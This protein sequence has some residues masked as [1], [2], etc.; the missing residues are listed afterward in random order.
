MKQK[1]NTFIITCDN[2][3]V[4]RFQNGSEELNNIFVAQDT[5]NLSL[6]EVKGKTTMQR[7]KS[8]LGQTSGSNECCI[9]VIKLFFHYSMSRSNIT[10]EMCVNKE[11]LAVLWDM[12]EWL[13]PGKLLNSS[14]QWNRLCQ[15]C[16]ACIN[17]DSNTHACKPTLR[18]YILH[19][20]Y[21]KF[22]LDKEKQRKGGRDE[23]GHGK[24]YIPTP[25][26]SWQ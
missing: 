23:D 2:A 5:Q 10:L 19:L 9:N 8:Q 6:D 17:T 12:S 18:C 21:I 7:W 13:Q 20:Q 14:K 3:I 25:P 4:G 1:G 15:C 26:S 16:W 24:L 11:P 22:A